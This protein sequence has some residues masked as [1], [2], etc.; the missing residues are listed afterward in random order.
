MP[1]APKLHSVQDQTIMGQIEK[2][3]AAHVKAKPVEAFLDPLRE[4]QSASRIAGTV[5]NWLTYPI[6]ERKRL[7]M[8]SFAYVPPHRGDDR[9]G[10]TPESQKEYEG[11]Q[12]ERW[13]AL[14]VVIQEE[15]RAKAGNRSPEVAIAALK[16]LFPDHEWKTP[17]PG[18]VVAPPVK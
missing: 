14:N 3:K 2:L 4:F 17:A 18:S 5:R 6:E 15:S 13:R 1:Q 7:I 12:L 8:S 16:L 11:R 10:V 9:T